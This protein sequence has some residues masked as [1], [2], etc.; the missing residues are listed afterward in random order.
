M[1]NY[2]LDNKV[3]TREIE[4]GQFI[5]KDAGSQGFDVFLKN[6]K[7]GKIDVE[8]EKKL[9]LWLNQKQFS[10]IVNAGDSGLFYANDVHL[11]GSMIGNDTI[12]N[13]GLSDM[14][15]YTLTHNSAYYL[16]GEIYVG[17]DLVQK[18][19]TDS[20]G[21]FFFTSTDSPC[22]HS[23]V[24]TTNEIYAKWDTAPGE[25]RIVVSY[26]YAR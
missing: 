18:F 19:S 5:F 8:T 1:K 2:W 26:E 16:V 24:L 25:N 15:V 17:D 20:L 11:Y 23:A 21:N 14:Q 12:N 10:N 9:A 7:I 4:L 13:Y 22:I 3:Y 6:E